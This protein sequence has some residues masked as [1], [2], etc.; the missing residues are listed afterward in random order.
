MPLEPLRAAGAEQLLVGFLTLFFQTSLV[1]PYTSLSNDSFHFTYPGLAA[2]LA[3]TG[4]MY[5]RINL[6]VTG[7]NAPALV[8]N[9]A[10]I[11]SGGLIHTI[12]TLIS[13]DDYNWVGTKA[14]EMLDADGDE[15]DPEE[16]S[17][18]QLDH[19]FYWILKWGS[20]FTVIMVVFWPLLTLPA[21]DFNKVI[22]L[23][24]VFHYVHMYTLGFIA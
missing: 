19:A 6:D 8:G 10:A 22:L 17:E 16:Y 14:I 3:T 7:R 21:K 20:L 1:N 9:L 4:V 24:D 11:L 23:A 12:F 2:W 13:P 5:G 18:E 15:A